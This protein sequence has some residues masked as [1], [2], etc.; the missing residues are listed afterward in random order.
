MSCGEKNKKIFIADDEEVVCDLYA[1]ELS[2]EGY[3]VVST[4]DCGKLMDMIEQ[5]EPDLVVLDIRMGE[6]N[7]LDLLQGVRNAYDTMPVILCSAYSSYK[8]DLRSIGADSYVV[9]SSDLTELKIQINMALEARV[10]LLADKRIKNME[11]QDYQG[12][13]PAIFV[14]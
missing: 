14:G 11:T 12:I 2:S 5:Y 1:E 13:P 10:S 8:Y 7:G 4:S 3:E 6:Y 9:K